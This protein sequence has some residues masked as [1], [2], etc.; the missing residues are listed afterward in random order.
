MMELDSVIER[1]VWD[2]LRLSDAAHA[3]RMIEQRIF[4][5]LTQ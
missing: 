2:L 3:E 4:M 1:C 5:W